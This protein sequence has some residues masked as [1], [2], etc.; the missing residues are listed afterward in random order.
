MNHNLKICASR[1]HAFYIPTDDAVLFD[2]LTEVNE[3]NEMMLQCLRCEGFY[4]D[5]AKDSISTK[6]A[7]IPVIIRGDANK[8]IGRLRL[9][10]FERWVRTVF[11]FIISFGLFHLSSKGSHIYKSFVNLTQAAT[12]L[13]NKL[14]FSIPHSHTLNLIEHFLHWSHTRYLTLTFVIFLYAILQLVE[15]FGLWIGSRWGEYLAATA[16]ATFIPVEIYEVSH[17]AS[18]SKIIALIVN[19]GVVAYLV[20]KDR[21][22]GVRG[23]GVKYYQELYATTLLSDL[24]KE[25]AKPSSL[26]RGESLE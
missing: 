9:I 24:E 8:H 10:A 1:G 15:G 11:L 12:P 21:L 14:G 26:A 13:A 3:K 22:F 4:I 7:D 6:R 25:E 18:Y 23:G 17:S 20:I 19:L 16:T 5:H 2:K